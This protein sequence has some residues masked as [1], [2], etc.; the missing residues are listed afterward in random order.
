MERD[1]MGLEEASHRLG[2]D[3]AF[4]VRCVREHWVVPG[5]P[6]ELDTEDLARLELVRELRE[7]FGVNDEAIPVILHLVDELNF[8]RNRM[9]ELQGAREKARRAE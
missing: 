1:R 2:V 6:F 4:V 3:S 5:G 9:R 8:T 7:D